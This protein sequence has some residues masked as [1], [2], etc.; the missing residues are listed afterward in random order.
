[1]WV[2]F[3]WCRVGS[4]SVRGGALITCTIYPHVA[5]Q[6]RPP[7]CTLLPSK[8]SKFCVCELVELALA[9]GGFRLK[10][11]LRPLGCGAP[12]R[13]AGPPPG[14]VASLGSASPL[15]WRAWPGALCCWF[16]R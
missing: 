13:S 1:M 12:P 3:R 4:L 9:G 10:L 15:A 7:A 11:L 6:P 14:L 2:V 16:L 8:V 5:N